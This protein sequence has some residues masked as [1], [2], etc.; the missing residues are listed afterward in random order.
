MVGFP[1]ILGVPAFD[2]FFQ[3]LAEISGT[4]KQVGRLDGGRRSF[5]EGL[6]D[7]GSELHLYIRIGLAGVILEGHYAP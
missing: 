3:D 2:E 5:H 4:G 7:R 1:G 6:W